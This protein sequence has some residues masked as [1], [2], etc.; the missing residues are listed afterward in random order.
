MA[1][2]NKTALLTGVAQEARR[3]GLLAGDHEVREMLRLAT[4]FAGFAIV[5]STWSDPQGEAR[6]VLCRKGKGLVERVLGV[7]LPPAGDASHHGRARAEPAI[8]GN[9]PTVVE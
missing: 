1:L 5:G 4:P 9:V 6:G 8:E 3:H 2:K 7:E